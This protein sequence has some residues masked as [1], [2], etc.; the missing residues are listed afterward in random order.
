MSDSDP[1]S[2]RS[3]APG[4]AAFETTHWSL[5]VAGGERESGR[6]EEALEALFAQYWYPL[7]VFV[8]SKVRDSHE[9][10]DVTQD[11][12]TFLLE[13]NTLS[14]ASPDRGRFRSFLLASVKNFLANHRQK[15][16]AQKRGGGRRQLSLDFDDGERRFSHEPTEELTPERHFD[17]QWAIT[18]LDAVL[19]HLRSEYVESD[20]LAQFDAMKPFISI[21]PD[22]VT[23]R[24]L[25]EQLAITEN[26]ATVAVHRL[27]KRYRQLLRSEIA[28]TV[29]GPG[30]IDDEI[31]RLFEALS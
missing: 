31:T 6:R 22:D 24:S 30:E 17:R 29:A 25:S 8:R 7:Y 21:T 20:R 23:Y 5:V 15:Q 3:V 14:V 11:F 19:N 27:R 12:F 9:A 18:L 4:N 16:S 10:R 13:K 28:K 2:I 26:A 1:K